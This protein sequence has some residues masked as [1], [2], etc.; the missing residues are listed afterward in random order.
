MQS[1]LQ[2]SILFLSQFLVLSL[3]K[4]L[5]T[6]RLAQAALFLLRSGGL[7]TS[8]F[9]RDVAKTIALGQN[10]DGGYSDVRETVFVISLLEQLGGYDSQVA[11]GKS[12]IADERLQG[13]WGNSKR[14]R[15]RIPTTGL[16]HEFL[17]TLATE[18]S[19]DWMISEWQRDAKQRSLLSYKTAF[20]LMSV[21]GRDEKLQSELEE[22]LLSEQEENGGFGPWRQHPAGPEAWCTGIALSALACRDT[23]ESYDSGLRA[24]RYLKDTQCPQGFWPYHYLDTGASWALYGMASFIRAHL[25]LSGMLSECK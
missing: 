16:V 11:R 18:E 23:H 22:A 20:V 7:P 9:I 13:G 15:M 17:P 21:S 24:L 19:R 4:K 6:V 1:L 2:K 8:P 12:W 10:K 14:D 5:D 3:Q 25:E